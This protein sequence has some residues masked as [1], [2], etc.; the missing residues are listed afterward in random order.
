[1]L[2]RDKLPAGE[3]SRYSNEV[4]I[5]VDKNTM[6]PTGTWKMLMEPERFSVADSDTKT[7]DLNAGR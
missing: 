4:T 6:G 1:M 3:G 7:V 2:H 5:V